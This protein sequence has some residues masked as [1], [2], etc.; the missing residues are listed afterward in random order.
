M[1]QR[2]KYTLTGKGNVVRSSC[3]HS[4]EHKSDRVT[5]P[6]SLTYLLDLACWNVLQARRGAFQLAQNHTQH[7]TAL[8]VPHHR[9]RFQAVRYRMRTDVRKLIMLVEIFRACPQF[10]AASYQRILNIAPRNACALVP[11]K[12][13]KKTG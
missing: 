9:W 10:D 12:H 1:T 11:P 4:S 6:P 5:T 2:Q 8:G 7:V 3:S 13:K